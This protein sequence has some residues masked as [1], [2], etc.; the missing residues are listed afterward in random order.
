MSASII[1]TFAQ[2]S[3]KP[4]DEVKT[5]LVKAKETVTADN[6]DV[7][8]GSEKFY[9]L[10]LGELRKMLSIK[11]E[12]DGADLGGIKYSDVAP[13]TTA[14]LTTV[15]KKKRQLRRSVSEA[16]D[17]IASM[18]ADDIGVYA[19]LQQ[20]GNELSVTMLENAI[21]TDQL[22][23]S[24]S[25]VKLGSTVDTG[26]SESLLYLDSAIQSAV[27][28]KQ[29]F[30]NFVE[31]LASHLLCAENLNCPK[32][33][34][35]AYDLKTKDNTFVS[36]KSSS[37]R[38]TVSEAFRNSNSVKTSAII[39]SALYRMD[40]DEYR[41]RCSFNDIAD[42]LEIKDDLMAFVESEESKIIFTVSFVNRNN[43]FRTHTTVPVPETQVLEH[44]FS[45]IEDGTGKARS[46]FCS[47]YKALK[48]FCGGDEVTTVTL[49][50]ASEYAALRER[51]ISKIINIKDYGLM[52]KIELLLQ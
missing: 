52:Q 40:E 13:G 51:I 16:F 17:A 2:K 28:D 47:S 1:K 36:V 32:F 27:S 12:N 25:H 49:M 35:P 30:A 23:E 46:K 6:P 3:G 4:E 38:H 37:S 10:L 48:E 5:A 43:E 8:S 9:K 22:E 39:L 20:E 24:M 14:G 41:N 29:N 45:I 11:T 18:S 44:A 31:T 15:H 21:A 50:D 19:A 26:K 33:E 42:L 34:Y 7:K